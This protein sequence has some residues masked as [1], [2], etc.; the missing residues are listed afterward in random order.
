[1][2]VF[3]R[4]ALQASLPR[5]VDELQRV[6]LLEIPSEWEFVRVP[7]SSLRADDELRR[8]VS[9][10]SRQWKNAVY[11][12]RTAPILPATLLHQHY[13]RW[14]EGSGQSI[15]KSRANAEDAKRN[16]DGILYVGSRASKLRQ[17]IRQH[18]GTQSVRPGIDILYVCTTLNRGLR[19]GPA[20]GSREPAEARSELRRSDAG[21]AGSPAGHQGGP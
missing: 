3:V 2:T 8:Y 15:H 17:G 13:T 11:L 21:L 6:L 12:V 10:I 1:M 18:I 9:V 4:E 19:V 20:Q 14:A 7:S 16:R 5:M